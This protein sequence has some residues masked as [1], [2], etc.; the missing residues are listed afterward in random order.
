MAVG[1]ISSLLVAMGTSDCEALRDAWLAQP[2]N[3]WSSGA[4]LL[5][6]GYLA[7]RHRATAAVAR[8]TA[9][10]ALALG[11]V[12]VGSFLY[13]GPQPAW[14]DAVHDAS[15]ALLLGTLAGRGG[16]AGPVSVRHR[17]RIL[18]V[19]VA[20]ALVV[21]VPGSVQAVHGALVGVVGISTVRTVRRSGATPA[22]QVA[23]VALAAGIALFAVGRTGGPLCEPR[24]LAQPHAGWHVATAIAAAALVTTDLRARRPCR[25]AP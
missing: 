21:A 13:H 7:V 14:G 4:Y 11:A 18:F 5:A 20:A 25:T 22:V 19:V 16:A 9:P 8:A 24:S 6:G 12:A 10:A 17:R 3:A 2:A 23:L 15:I 1:E